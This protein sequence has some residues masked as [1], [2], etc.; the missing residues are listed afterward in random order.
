MEVPCFS[1]TGLFLHVLFPLPGPPHAELGFV[2]GKQR[3]QG[4]EFKKALTRVTH[5]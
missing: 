1:F 4:T 5:V 2:G 3:T